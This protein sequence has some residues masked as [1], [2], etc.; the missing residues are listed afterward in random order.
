MR[1]SDKRQVLTSDIVDVNGN[2]I[3]ADGIDWSRY[4]KN[5]ILKYDPKYEGHGGVVVGHVLDIKREGNTHTGRLA[6]MERNEV[7]DIAYEK[8]TQGILPY[9]SIGGFGIGYY[10]EEI[11]VFTA[12]AYH[13]RENS[14]VA[15]PAN[16]EARKVE[17]KD[18][19]S[20]ADRKLIKRS[21]KDGKEV[22]YM[23]MCATN[24]E[25]NNLIF[26]GMEPNVLEPAMQTVN[27]S[28]EPVTEP[29][30]PVTQTVNASAESATE[31]NVDTVT[32]PVTQ[33]IVA[34]VET[35]P[36]VPPAEPVAQSADSIDPEIDKIVNA[37][38][39]TSNVQTQTQTINASVESPPNGMAWH[40]PETN[41]IKLSDMNKTYQE[42][43]CDADFQKRMN[44]LNAAYRMGAGQSDAT[45]ENADTVKAL[46]CAMLGDEKMVM[47]AS[48]T[49][50]TD[51]IT[52]TRKNGLT[53]LVEAAAGTAAAATLAAADL[54]VI[55]YLSLVYE[56]L[57]AN[58][59][60]RRSIRYVPMSD[61][62]GAIFIE[63]GI[64]VP[65]SMGSRSPINAPIYTYDDI[66]R[67]IERKVVHFD[68]V[69]FQH[70][71]L[72]VLAYDKQNL[73]IRETF[74]AMMESASTYWL[75]V[76]TNTPNLIKVGTSGDEVNT[77]GLFPIEAPNSNVNIHKPTLNDIVEGVEGG[78][79]MQNY[80]FNSGKRVEMV[81]P[82]RIYSMLAGDP[83]VRNKLI[84]ELNGNLASHI[85]FSATRITP[86]NPVAR[87]NTASDAF[88]LDQSMYMD[89]IVNNDGTLTNVTPA[90]TTADHIGAGIAFVENEVIAGIGAIELIV[91][92]QPEGYGTLISGWMSTGA[93]VAR[94]NGVGVVG[95]VPTLV[96]P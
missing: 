92:P 86:R 73:G 40:E 39:D 1:I 46:A 77:Q 80:S 13:P 66:K 54:G 29:T 5:P 74:G 56:Q 76:Y 63:S 41:Q 10:D 52:Q 82:A 30:E 58:D 6:F 31:P 12:E 17:E 45:P 64:N 7:A 53:M 2:R 95:V 75:Q 94:S 48:V 14:L 15:D 36:V 67:T 85:N 71:D 11:N 4:L 43:N 34:S 78:F 35:P 25:F 65:I 3:L 60:F 69:L 59:T 26:K 33:P 81:L 57:H 24:E 47:L 21:N 16:I 84:K 38:V 8:Y 55:K 22:R 89:K 20:S 18:I 72:A 79:L 37:S 19:Q 28:A 83:E 44:A 32:E 61:R 91:R 93:T 68:P 49:H 62:T 9:T 51:E 87:Y 88:E 23:T 27:A 96:T 90:V 42:L 50:V 70:S